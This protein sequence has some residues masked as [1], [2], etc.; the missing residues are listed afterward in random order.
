MV[1]GGQVE[2]RGSI[3]DRWFLHGGIRARR[4][5]MLEWDTLATMP[6]KE[7]YEELWDGDAVATSVKLIE[8]HPRWQWFRQQLHLLP[9]HLR[10]H[11]AG[12][13]P[14]NGLLLSHRALAAVVEAEIRLRISSASCV[15]GRCSALRGS[16]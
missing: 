2:Q 3:L 4:Y 12:V 13:V 5:L 7:F 14:F 1:D 16:I 11:A 8:T 6:V 9:P 10:Q 15:S